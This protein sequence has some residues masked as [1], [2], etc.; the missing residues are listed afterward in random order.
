[1]GVNGIQW[2]RPPPRDAARTTRKLST[3]NL[4][5]GFPCPFHRENR[6][7][8]RPGKPGSFANM[9]NKKGKMSAGL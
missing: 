3:V 7:R 6:A 5:I 9:L 4:K 1:M 8:E 2:I